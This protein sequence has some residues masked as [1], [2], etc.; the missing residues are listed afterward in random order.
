[1]TPTDREALALALKLT[2]A[3]PL[4]TEQIERML[5]EDGWESAAMFACYHRQCQALN[6]FNETPP[7]DV[8]DPDAALAGPNDYDW[9]SEVHEAARLA[10][11]MQALGISRFHPDPPAAIEAAKARRT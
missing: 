9:C 4:R 10:K 2:M 6:L 3:E 7:M 8:D 11:Q 1:M 5:A